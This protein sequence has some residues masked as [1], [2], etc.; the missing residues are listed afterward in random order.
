MER[1][2]TED[3]WVRAEITGCQDVAADAVLAT[4]YV[5]CRSSVGGDWLTCPNT[6]SGR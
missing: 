2:L 4:T 6:W 3:P 1:G 5:R